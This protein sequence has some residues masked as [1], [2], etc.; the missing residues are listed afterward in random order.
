MRIIQKLARKAQDNWSEPGVTI[1][2]LGDSVTQGCFE[3]YTKADGGIETYFDKNSAYHSDFAKIL[4]VLYPSVP[5]NIINAGVSG[6]S[7]PHAY[8]RLERDVISRRPDLTVVCFG[9]NDCGAGPDGLET[10][11]GALEKIFSR[12]QE[13]NIEVIFLT[14]NMMCTGVSCHLEQ[15]NFR[16]VAEACSRRQNDGTLTAYLEK[17]KQICRARGIPVCDC[18]EKWQTLN[19]S[20][21]N[22]TELLANKIN[23]PSREMDWLFAISLVETMM[24]DE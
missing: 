3:L 1:A 21:V 16:N 10:Y 4:A 15:E 14:P 22:V 17:A 2:F 13:E 9:L 5:V 8:D 12:L 24:Q 7:A 19:R 20:G 23:H 11:A 6:G 18:Y